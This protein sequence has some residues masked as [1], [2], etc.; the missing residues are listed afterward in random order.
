MKATVHARNRDDTAE[1]AEALKVRLTSGQQNAM[2]QA[3]ERVAST[4]LTAIPMAKYGFG[5]QKQAFRDALC[6]RFGWTPERLS[7]HCSCGE[8][9]EEGA[10][11]DI[12]AQGF[13]GQEQEERV[14]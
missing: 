3:S 1:D 9:V 2:E 11:L 7:S 4:W 13:L 6:L 10:R 5:L 8:V 12:R 14:L